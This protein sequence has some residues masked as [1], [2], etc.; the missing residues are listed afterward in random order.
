MDSYEGVFILKP[1]LDKQA[2]D[3]LI[4]QLRGL[5]KKNEGDIQNVTD[6][7]K[8]K[9]A[10]LIDKKTEGIYY[11]FDFTLL[12][13][14]MKIVENVLKLNEAILRILIVKK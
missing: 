4:E 11:L 14:K 12:P 1:T 7:G 5:I 6:W 10:Y 3:D 2:Q 13:E 9:L 8:R